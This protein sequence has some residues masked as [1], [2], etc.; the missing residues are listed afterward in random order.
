MRPL[1]SRL[2]TAAAFNRP[3]DWQA[4]E[5]LTRDVFARITGDVHMDLNGRSGQPQSGVDVFGVDQRTRDRIGVQCR[6]RGDGSSWTNSR[7]S[8]AELRDEVSKAR[9]FYPKINVFVLLTTGPNDARLKKT[10]AKLDA[11][12]RRSNSFEV[13]V[14]GWDWL[15]GR[16]AEHLDLAVQY[17][18]IA[19]VT[20][21][22][23]SHQAASK[24]AHQIGSRLTAAIELMND[25][26]GTDDR[27]TLQNISQ[28]LGFLDWRQLEA[29][30]DGR[31]DASS[32]ELAQIAKRLGIN[33]RWLIEGKEAPFLV[34]PQDYMD[35][36]EQYES[37]RRLNPRRIIFVRQKQEQYQT[38]V[39]AEVDDFRW[40]TFHR[41]HPTSSNV[42]GT[43]RRQLFEFCCLIRRLYRCFDHPGGCACYGK[44]TDATEFMRLLEGEVYPGTLFHY[45]SSDQWWIDFAELAE[46][47]VE[48]Q[49][50]QAKELREAI[51]ITR[52]VLD[53]FQNRS[54]Q[55][56]WR[57][58]TLIEAGFPVCEAKPISAYFLDTGLDEA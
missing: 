44:H 10:A 38:I 2:T 23:H 24:I 40:V 22:Q 37:I 48:G 34:D 35:V 32:A 47:R 33:E 9:N 54:T 46:N 30:A 55:N 8:P 4:F 27:F 42:G 31:S 39:V 45:P 17:G 13:Q 36:D 18:L 58:D 11:R 52:G 25:R 19:V 3:R 1:T 7:V 5:R 57:R 50:S 29:I 16:L 53:E 41:D 6:G 43:G 15:E 21:D 12:H 51:L 49:S 26:R 56:S 20:P 28:H 14:H